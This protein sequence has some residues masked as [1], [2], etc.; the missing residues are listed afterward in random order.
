M[1]KLQFLPEITLQ[2]NEFLKTY[3]LLE[4]YDNNQQSSISSF[5]NIDDQQS[6][7]SSPKNIDDQ[8]PLSIPNLTNTGS[9]SLIASSNETVIIQKK[10]DKFNVLPERELE[11]L[12]LH[13]KL[14]DRAV[15]QIW[16]F[17]SYRDYNATLRC[18]LR[19]LI[20]DFIK[21]YRLTKIKQPT[22]QQVSEYITESNWIAFFKMPYRC[23]QDANKP[24][25]LYNIND[26]SEKLQEGLLY[27]QTNYE[28]PNEIHNSESDSVT[29][30]SNDNEL[31]IIKEVERQARRVTDYMQNIVDSETNFQPVT[32]DYSS[33]F[34]NFIEMLLFTW[35]IKHIITSLQ[36]KLTTL[37]KL[38]SKSLSLVQI[39][40]TII[41]CWIIVAKAF[42]LSFSFTFTEKMYKELEETLRIKNITLLKAKSFEVSSETHFDISS[43]TK[44]SEINIVLIE[45]LKRVL[46]SEIQQLALPVQ[47]DNNS[48]F[49]HDL[50]YDNDRFDSHLDL[51]SNDVI[52]IQE[53]NSI[54][55][56]ILK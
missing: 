7:T 52:Q 37:T 18:E 17:G 21:K 38:Y 25:L 22:V 29:S 33:Y 35:I 27:E 5:K 26:D 43:F 20:P 55:Y 14:L 49:T 1:S 4:E 30:V 53:E 23:L 10:S 40:N 8:Q 41:S 24:T 34:K 54:S 12:Q 48:Q 28:T 9:F 56:A 39:V 31:I 2:Q 32:G 36:R 44:E 16:A 51:H 42:C 47:L 19:K 46:K 6:S 13:L 3:H 11:T 45:I 50:I 15:L